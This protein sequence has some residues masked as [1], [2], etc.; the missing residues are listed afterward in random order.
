MG[1][2]ALPAYAQI[3]GAQIDSAQTDSFSEF[4]LTDDVLIDDVDVQNQSKFSEYLSGEIGFVGAYGG[5]ARRNNQFLDVDMDAPWSWGRFYASYGGVRYEYTV[6]QELD[7]EFVATADRPREKFLKVDA[8]TT[9]WRETFVQLN[10]GRAITLSAGRQRNAWGQFELFSPA[11]LMQ[12]LTSNIISFIPNKVDLLHAQDQVKLSMFPSSKSEIQFYDIENIRTDEAGDEATAL[13]LTP[14][15]LTTKTNILPHGDEQKK[16]TEQKAVRLLFYPSWGVLGF[17]RHEGVNGLN[18][19]LRAPVGNNDDNDLVA[20]TYPND[21][22]TYLF[23]PKGKLSAIEIAVTSNRYTWRL[24]HAKIET[25]DAPGI[26][27]NITLFTEEGSAFTA[28][29][30][31]AFNEAV[32]DTSRGNPFVGTP[33][34]PATRT[35]SGIGVKYDGPVWTISVDAFAISSYKP[36]THAGRRIE[37]TYAAL[38]D[39]AEQPDEIDFGEFPLISAYRSAGDE[40]QHYYGYALGLVGVGF[41]IGGV[42]SYKI[43]DDLSVAGSLGFVDV[44]GFEAEEGYRTKDSDIPTLQISVRWQF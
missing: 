37:D 19:L 11:A 17:T 27:G 22:E 25:Y 38:E 23:Y 32:K 8:E 40:N 44:S 35:L 3:D 5:F 28:P 42:Y 30:I 20:S 2:L 29:K 1:L 15:L 9:D 24:E 18:P 4:D 21:D 13:L 36:D 26:L 41:G 12:P 43:T 10:L 7:E 6:I 39:E 16:Y 34:F 33:I 31:D 14:R